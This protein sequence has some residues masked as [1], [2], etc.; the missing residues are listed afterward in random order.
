MVKK[1]ILLY[2]DKE[3]PYNVV[4]LTNY[5]FQLKYKFVISAVREVNVD[6]RTLK[7]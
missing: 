3:C 5:D 1:S 2:S 6:F 7:N 4:Y